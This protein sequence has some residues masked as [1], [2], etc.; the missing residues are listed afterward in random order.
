[1]LSI[2]HPRIKTKYPS[3]F[4]TASLQAVLPAYTAVA[5]NSSATGA[6][7]DMVKHLYPSARPR[8]PPRRSSSHVPTAST[9]PTVAPDPEG[10]D[11]PLGTDEAALQ[12]RLLQSFLTFVAE[13]YV[14]RLKAYEDIPGMAWSPR[15][16][17]KTHPDKHIPGR[18]SYLA[19]FVE[20][21]E[22]LHLRDTLLGQC[23]VSDSQLPL[24]SSR[25][26]WTG[27]IKRP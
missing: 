8:L 2:L 9:V 21:E 15:Y 12:A 24:P 11:V 17:E 1:M 23:L 22:E 27:N 4:L 7:L 18:S 16:Y 13:G 14:S 25:L 19:M 20:E 10:Q 5:Q 3:R 26:I 6:T